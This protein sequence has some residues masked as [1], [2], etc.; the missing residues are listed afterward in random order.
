MVFWNKVQVSALLIIGRF[1]GFFLDNVV[2][3]MFL[4]FTD[5]LLPIFVADFF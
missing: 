5:N 1:L 3:T 4:C 2:A